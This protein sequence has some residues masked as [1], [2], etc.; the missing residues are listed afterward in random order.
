AKSGARHRPGRRSTSRSSAGCSKAP[1]TAAS[2]AIRLLWMRA[3]ERQTTEAQRHRGCTEK[4]RK[5][6]E[7]KRIPKCEK[8]PIGPSLSSLC[9]LCVSV[10]LWFVF[11]MPDFAEQILIA[12]ARKAYVPLKPKALARKL[13]VPSKQYGDF[14]RALRELLSQGRVEIGKNHSV[15]G[16]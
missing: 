10:T 12:V 3:T 16:A 13:S 2:R 4:K 9:F 15:R 14:R 7:Y 6:N 11:L 5:E 8:K 1:A